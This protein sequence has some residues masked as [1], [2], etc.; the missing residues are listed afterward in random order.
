MRHF[1]SHPSIQNIADCSI[2]FDEEEVLINVTPT[3]SQK[4]SSQKI[5]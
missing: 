1:F 5:S 3:T 2:P 4:N